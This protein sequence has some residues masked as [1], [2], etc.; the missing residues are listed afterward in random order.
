MNL[1]DT[2]ELIIHLKNTFTPFEF[3]F[4]HLLCSIL[5]RLLTLCYTEISLSFAQDIVHHTHGGCSKRHLF[6]NWVCFPLQVQI[7]ER[8]SNLPLKELVYI[9]G[10]TLFEMLCSKNTQDDR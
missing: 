4:S 5:K 6:R 2:K 9:T 10:R 3:K 8:N 7:G 1:A